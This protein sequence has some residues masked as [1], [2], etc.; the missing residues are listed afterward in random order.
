VFGHHLQNSPS[1]EGLA[2]RKE[3]LWKAGEGEGEG[4]GEKERRREGEKRR[5]EGERRREKER[6]R[7]GEK[8]RERAKRA[9]EGQEV[10][11]FEFW[12]APGLFFPLFYP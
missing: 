12:Q 8:E 6:R 10:S 11:L 9:Q 4:E 2:Y 3:L 1:D 5:R 7:E